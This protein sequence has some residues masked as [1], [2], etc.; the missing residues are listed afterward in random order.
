MPKTK[1]WTPRRVRNEE[2]RGTGTSGFITLDE[3][4]KFLGY[5]LFEAD[6]AEDDPAYYEYLDHWNTAARRSVP[7]AGDDCVFCEDGDKP[8]DIALTVWLVVKDEKGNTLDPPE[9]RIFR[10]NSIVIK[11]LTEMR[12]EDETIKG[13]QF[14]V[15]RMDDRGNYMLQPKTKS[16]K[17]S[18]VKEALKDKDA[19]DLEQMVTGQ[20]RRAMEGI[21]V[22]RAMDDDDDDDDNEQTQAGK[23]AKKTADKSKNGTGDEDWPEDGLDEEEVTVAKVDKEGNWI[24]ATS[25]EYDGKV[26]VWTTDSIEFDLTDL[27]KGDTVTVSADGP[28]DDGEY[29]LN[30]EPETEGA[31][32]DDDD[33]DAAKDDGEAEGGDLPDAIEDEEF[34]V[35]AIDTSESTIDVENDELELEFTLYFLDKGPASKVDFDDYEEGAKIKVSAEKDSQGDMVATEIPEVVTEKKSKKSGAKTSGGKKK[36]GK[37]KR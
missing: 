12:S 15:T 22:A 35:T 2:E 24:E 10:A 31:E 25:D 34:T 32:P 23:K 11:Q 27:S 4:E 3:G 20:L 8:R 17:K 6:P 36:G 14:R 26:K 33:D 16:L 1:K 37:G 29:I 5:A 7:C 30:A 9:L 28:D 18:E 19:P 13:T 21:A